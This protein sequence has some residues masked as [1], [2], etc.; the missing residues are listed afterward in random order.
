MLFAGGS[1]GHESEA[2][3][4]QKRP[5]GRRHR[6]VDMAEQMASIA[7]PNR[8]GVATGEVL[9][10][11]RRAIQQNRMSSGPSFM[12]H[13]YENSAA[14]RQAPPAMRRG[15]PSQSDKLNVF[16]WEQN[17][18][19]ETG[20][21][22]RGEPR[23]AGLLNGTPRDTA[24]DIRQRES[25]KFESHGDSHFLR[26]SDASTT[27]QTAG[28]KGPLKASG[29]EEATFM[30]G[31]LR[32]EEQRRSKRRAPENS[33]A[34]L[35]PSVEGFPGMGKGTACKRFPHLQRKV[36]ESNVFPPAI[37]SWAEDLNAAPAKSALRPTAE[38]PRD[39]TVITHPAPKGSNPSRQPLES[40][41]EAEDDGS[42]YAAYLAAQKE[43]Q[44]Q[45]EAEDD[46]RWLYEDQE[47]QGE[48]GVQGSY[49]KERR[50]PDGRFY[51]FDPKA[52]EIVSMQR[53]GQPPQSF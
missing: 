39:T 37:P 36:V 49:D 14:S 38:V 32:D 35:G 44:Q 28:K 6:P 42:D 43:M 52:H 31:L 45:R 25:K 20:G 19:A 2:R 53:G 29:K 8:D 30:D 16:S 12:D 46:P 51:S 5:T 27:P 4:A 7:S 24:E 26:F 21:R 22:H 33:G 15:H 41:Y 23:D 47:P 3:D 50:V 10:G 13:M 48:S 1:F 40:S 34:Q 11:N 17:G 9:P 18:P